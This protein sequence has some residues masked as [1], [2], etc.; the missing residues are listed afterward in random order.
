MKLNELI[1]YLQTLPQE[2]EVEFLGYAAGFDFVERVQK[3]DFE[4]IDI[5]GEPIVRIKADWN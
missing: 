5:A 4:V 3:S 2:A 1:E